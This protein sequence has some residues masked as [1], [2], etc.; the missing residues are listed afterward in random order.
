MTTQEVA[1]KLVEYCRNNQESRAYEELYSPQI[2][3][4]EMSEPMKEVQGFEG[5]KKK[6]QWW[7]DNFEVHG[8]KFSDPIIADNHFA[9][10]IWMDTTHK[11]SGQRS[12]MNEIAV[13]Q[14]KEGKIW[15]EQFFYDTEQ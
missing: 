13:Y 3:S 6:G 5:I 11:S 1:Q 9:V 12:Q 7:N 8:T 10:N 14:V 15:R 2:T 4:V